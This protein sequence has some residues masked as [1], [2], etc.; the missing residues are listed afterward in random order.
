MI[1]IE[2]QLS[3]GGNLKGLRASGHAE[4]PAGNNVPCAA[5]SFL[6]RSAARYFVEEGFLR[7][8]DA[9][10]AGSLEFRL[11]DPDG[12]GMERLRGAGGLLLRGLSDLGR[13]YPQD[14][15]LDMRPGR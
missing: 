3:A 10:E 9:P 15:E 13:E 2:V 11:L 4:G 12:S 7:D 5:V 6:L 14:V 8:G 1:R